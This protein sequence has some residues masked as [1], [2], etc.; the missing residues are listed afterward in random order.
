MN[1]EG[2]GCFWTV[3]LILF[4]LF[5]GV[6]E[7]AVEPEPGSPP[8]MMTPTPLSCSSQGGLVLWQRVK[9]P[10]PLELQD[11][12]SAQGQGGRQRACRA[13]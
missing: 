7:M 5:M 10:A 11:K 4:A 1:A 8:A 2:S 3:M 9:A 13:L 12:I 6:R